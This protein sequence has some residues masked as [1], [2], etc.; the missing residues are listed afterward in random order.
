MHGLDIA[1]A[2]LLALSVLVGAWR[3]LVFELM[4][5]LGWLVAYVV[6]VAYSG[7]F[8]PH[9]PIGEQ[10]S[11]LNHAA[12][13]VVTFIGALVLWAMLARLLQMVISATPL[14]VPDRFLGAVF[15]CVRGMVLLLL[16]VTVL[17]L[18]P[19]AKSSWWQQSRGVQL[20]GVL[21]GGLR[22]LMPEE[23]ARWLLPQR[24]RT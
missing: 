6:A 16:L 9:L 7:L 2:V 4:S 22:P 13:L 21:I 8:S 10:G 15:G 5:L 18:T 12:S 24:Q 19:T 11:A 3:G 14:T 23:L 20:M 17:S 1:M